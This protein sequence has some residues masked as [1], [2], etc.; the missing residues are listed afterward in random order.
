[1]TS[2]E[3]KKYID[4]D[5]KHQVAKKMPSIFGGPMSD[6]IDSFKTCTSNSVDDNVTDVS[7]VVSLNTD[8]KVDDNSSKKEGTVM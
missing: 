3:M 1:M 8:L 2:E 5:R 7:D 6:K 4:T